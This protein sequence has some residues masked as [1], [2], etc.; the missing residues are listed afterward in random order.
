MAARNSKVLLHNSVCLKVNFKAKV[1][2]FP[3]PMRLI[4]PE[5]FYPGST[6]VPA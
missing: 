6:K 4:G 5:N 1:V 2:S 3:M